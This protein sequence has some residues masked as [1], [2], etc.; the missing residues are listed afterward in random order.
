MNN[1]NNNVDMSRY[2]GMSNEA[3]L[4]VIGDLI[5][6]R[7]ENPMIRR[8]RRQYTSNHDNPEMV[9]KVSAVTAK[10][11]EKIPRDIKVTGYCD[12]AIIDLENYA[13]FDSEII[14][15]EDVDDSLFKMRSMLHQIALFAG[16]TMP[17]DKRAN[18][19]SLFEI[20]DTW[21]EGAVNYYFEMVK[22]LSGENKQK[23][24][25]QRQKVGGIGINKSMFS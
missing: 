3:L 10:E 13:I 20:L 8:K 1:Q 16:K 22:Q 11:L 19:T 18:L 14:D 21:E 5:R 6:Q 4:A 12:S 7:D 9:K 17:K 15:K 25:Q 2:Q 24:R 23:N